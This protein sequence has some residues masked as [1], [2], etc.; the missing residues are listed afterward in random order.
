MRADPLLLTAGEWLGAAS[1]V[2]LVL[3]VVAF[4][5]R[6]GIRFR[7]VGVTSFTVLLSL[8][9][10]AFAVSYTPRQT[11]EGAISVPVVFDNGS[12]LVVAAAPADMPLET[13]LPS[14]EQVAI[15]LRGSGRGTQTV[16]VR[17]RR[18]ES[19]ADGTDTPVVL[20]TAIRNLADGSVSLRG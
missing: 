11:V 9:C 12:D 19:T 15:N 18:V 4:L 3:T 20:A 6:W 13:F 2:L 14:V 17:L 8:S 7:L 1:A 5:V 16:E 10:L